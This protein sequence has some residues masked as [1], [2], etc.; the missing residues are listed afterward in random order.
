MIADARNWESG[1]ARSVSRELHQARTSPVRSDVK[2]R[3]VRFRSQLS[4]SGDIRIN[5]TRIERGKILVRYLEPFSYARRKVGNE[6]IDP[7]HKAGQNL[8]SSWLLQINGGASPGAVISSEN[9]RPIPCSSDMRRLSALE[10]GS[11]FSQK[12]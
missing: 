1:R 3:F 2:S 7:L 5:Q 9:P 12:S 11:T 10:P 8:S 6:Y 4:V